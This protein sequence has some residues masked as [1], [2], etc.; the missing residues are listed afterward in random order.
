MEPMP[1][2]DQLN[3][4]EKDDLLRFL[5]ARVVELTAK[6]T[7][8]EG[9]LALN[10]RNASKPLSSEGYGKP[11]PKS[12]RIAGKNP[13]GGQKGHKGHTLEKSEHPA[14]LVPHIPPVNC[15]CGME[16]PPGTVVETRQVF[17]LP[18]M[19]YEVTEHQVLRAVAPAASVTVVSFPKT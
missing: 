2:L 11:K 7:E 14:H 12:L 16:L 18:P 1:D 19:R 3:A 8:L 5:Y 13:T 15:E 4:T 10:S 17:A 6:V 9:R